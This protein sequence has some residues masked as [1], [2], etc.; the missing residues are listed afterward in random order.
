MLRHPHRSRALPDDLRHL[1][2][3][4][5][6]EDAQEEDLRLVEGELAD[7]R[8]HRCVDADRGESGALRVVVGGA[9]V[10][11]LEA[12]AGDGSPVVAVQV[13][14]SPPRDGEHERAERHHVALQA[15]KRAGDVHPDLGGQVVR[16]PA[17]PPPEVPEKARIEPSVEHAEAVVVAPPRGGER[18][19]ELLRRRFGRSRHGECYERRAGSD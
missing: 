4:E 12:G 7:D 10:R 9:V 11:L 17:R 8:G 13:D 2:H 6:A 15:R 18:D 1:R 5:V 14:Q 19:R 16:R 3:V